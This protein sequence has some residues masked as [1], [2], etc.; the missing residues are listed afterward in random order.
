MIIISPWARNTT[1]G[2]PSPKNYPYWEAVVSG[3]G[4]AGYEITQLSCSGEPDVPGA[5][6]VNDLS[7]EKLAEFMKTCDT[8]ISVDNFFHHMAWSIGQPGIV[9]F[10]SSDPNIFGHTENINLLRDRRFLKVRQFGLWSQEKPYPEVF[11]GPEAVVNA[12]SL[13]ILQRD[14]RLTLNA[15]IENGNRPSGAR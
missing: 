11:V 14:V 13:S 8:W 9:I 2:K 15:E 3:L 10:G 4:K 12:V 6:R 5:R 1:E 7:L